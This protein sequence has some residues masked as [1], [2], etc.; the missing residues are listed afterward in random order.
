MKNGSKVSSAKPANI[1]PTRPV[2]IFYDQR[3]SRRLFSPQDLHID[4]GHRQNEQEQ[5]QSNGRP[6]AEV[7]VY[8]GLISMRSTR[9]RLY[10]A[11]RAS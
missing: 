10:P 4:H 7:A 3:P 8:K 11:H 1:S 6:I 5:H 9:M 2:Y